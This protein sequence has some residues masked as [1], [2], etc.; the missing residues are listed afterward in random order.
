VPDTPAPRRRYHSARR[1]AQA[2][3]TRRD[4]M[5]TARR[6]LRER[7][8]PATTVADV[9]RAA[10]VS[11]KTV[12]LAFATKRDLLMAVWDS[13]IS[14]KDDAVPVAERDWFREAL[15]AADPHEQLELVAR[16]SRQVKERAADMM[17]VVRSAASVDAELAQLWRG[18]QEEFHANQRVVIEAL[19]AKGG[20]RNG[21]DMDEATDLLWTLNHPSVYQ[22]LVEQR[23]WS[24]DRYER[25]LATLLR[26]QLTDPPEAERSLR[27]PAD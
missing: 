1:Q 24:P 27:A 23:G 5:H 21:L 14:G 26:Q 3:A 7:G 12:Y 15:E 9:A 10:G 17:E 19:A 22:L 6:L 16:N 25:W 2:E 8:Y 13:A 4:I 20:L 18:M 11:T